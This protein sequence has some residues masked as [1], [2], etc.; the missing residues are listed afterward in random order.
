MHN[1][2][3]R[4]TTVILSPDHKSVTGKGVLPAEEMAG[5]P[6]EIRREKVKKRIF[7]LIPFLVIGVSLLMLWAF[8]AQAQEPGEE[9][10]AGLEGEGPPPGATIIQVGGAPA[11][12]D[13]PPPPPPPR[14]QR[15][16]PPTFDE[17]AAMDLEGVIRMSPPSNMGGAFSTGNYFFDDMESGTA[18]W[19]T[20]GLWHL[21]DDSDTYGNSYSATHSWWFGQNSTGNYD[22][23][24]HVTG[25][26]QT[27]SSINIPA[28]IPVCYLRFWS[29]EM[30]EDFL[31][32]YDTRRVYFS[33]DGG[34]TWLPGIYQSTASYG[35]WRR[36]H[37]DLG[38][39]L[40]PYAAAQTLDLRFEF[41][42]VD[43]SNN[44]YRGWYI[45][46]I[47]VG[48]DDIDIWMDTDGSGMGPP[49][50][51]DPYVTYGCAGCP[52]GMTPGGNLNAQDWAAGPN[53]FDITYSSP[54]WADV[55][56]WL[57]QLGVA[58]PQLGPF[59]TQIPAGTA[60]GAHQDISLTV[61][62]NAPGTR[63]NLSTVRVYHGGVHLYS[64]Q[65]IDDGSGQSVGNGNGQIDPGEIIE[66]V[67]T[68]E[69]SM[70]HTRRA[71]Q[72]VLTDSW[73]MSWLPAWQAY[74]DIGAGA[75]ASSVGKYLF[76]VPGGIPPGTLVTF[77][78][79]ITDMVLT[80]WNDSFQETVPNLTAPPVSVMA[81]AS[82]VYHRF[83]VR[84]TLQ[85]PVATNFDIGV[86][87]YTWPSVVD[88][89]QIAPPGGVLP[90]GWGYFTVTVD[91]PA[92]IAPGTET[93]A[94]VVV[95]ATAS[96][97][98]ASALIST[99]MMATDWVQ[100][101]ADDVNTPLP[102][103]DGAYLAVV[104]SMNRWTLDGGAHGPVPPPF[105]MHDPVVTAFRYDD[106]V[107]YA[108]SADRTNAY[109][110]PVREVS[111]GARKMDG[112][113][114]I[115]NTRVA[116]YSGCFP[117]PCSQ[118]QNPSIARVPTNGNIV[119]AWERQQ[120]LGFFDVYYAVYSANGTLLVG[121][122]N[123]TNNTG[124]TGI[125]DYSP[126]VEAF[127]DGRVALAWE[128]APPNLPI[129]PMSPPPFPLPPLTPHATSD[130]MYAILDEDGNMVVSTTNLTN[131]QSVWSETDWEP[132]LTQLQ[133]YDQLLVT[134][135]G[136][137]PA[138]FTFP[139]VAY[140]VLNSAGT[141][142]VGEQWLSSPLTENG[143]PNQ[144]PDA[145][146][147]PDG[148][149]VVAWSWYD[150]AATQ[151]RLLYS[152]LSSA[153]NV[154]VNP[155]VLAT[156]NLSSP[157]REQNVSL[158][159]DQSG[160][161]VLTWFDDWASPGSYG[162]LWY[163]WLAGDGTVLTSPRRYWVPHY[164]D[165]AFTN[166]WAWV[167]GYGQ[168]T[169]GMEIRDWQQLSV[170]K[171]APSQVVVGE[172]LTYTITVS[173]TGGVYT[174]AGV[175]VTDTVPANTTCCAS[176]GQGGLLVGND[177]TWSGLTISGGQSISL[178]FAVT[179]GQVASGTIITNDAY[180]VV[181]S[182]HRVTTGL[183]SEVTTTVLVPQLSIGKSA[184]S[185]VLPGSLMTYTLNVA[186][187][188]GQ[189]YATGVQVTDT[190]PA[191]TAVASIGQG[192]SLAGGEVVW[193][194]Q[195]V[196]QGSS[197]TLTF[198]VTV[199]QVSSG[200]IITND[201]YRVVSSDQGVNT[202]LGSAVTTT[203]AMP[204]LS[205]SKSAPSQVRP[206]ESL[207]YTL[208]VAETSGLLD[209]TGVQVTDTVPA[210]TA[211]AS[212]DQGGS[213]VGNDVTWSGLTVTRGQSIKL[214]FVVTV[215]SSVPLGTI[216]TNDAYRVVTSTQGINTGLGSAVNTTVSAV[217]APQLSINK[218]APSWVYSGEVLNYTIIVSETT[219]LGGAT[220]VQVTDTVPL[221]ATCCA[222][223][224]QGGSLVGNDVTWSSLV[225]S[226]GQ[227]ISLTFAVT[228]GKVLSGTII[229]N[230]AYRVVTSDQGVSTGLGNAV[231]T[232]VRMKP[233]FL[234]VI[235]SS[236]SATTTVI[237]Q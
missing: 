110:V 33:T 83:A 155:T 225:I 25:D 92:G 15:P 206:G 185:Q 160:N 236:P 57:P 47:A 108:W 10:V 183:G 180:Q 5:R 172:V 218:S 207:T 137:N 119:V 21:A 63:S 202:G 42:S 87:E 156:P 35:Q 210:N 90:L 96:S 4:R 179:V 122:T 1:T 153:L 201:A 77:N 214:T 216:I 65:I 175:Q 27:A 200:T 123:L 131:N 60:L 115:P 30:T 224:G 62:E 233:V 223:V 14:G 139:R 67:V 191:N 89:V 174:V 190:V 98:V 173:E 18:N 213:L 44:G 164:L 203:V 229:T 29:W 118:D 101:Y 20:S 157:T 152:V 109:G 159:A 199:G 52:S 75:T 11:S 184:A 51:N 54:S 204:Q 39:W 64:Y 235:R 161:A 116:D 219:G 193:S 125:S 120:I 176:I 66:L 228:V 99:T 38:P 61:T 36:H 147:L 182:T 151:L 167:S 40:A 46:D 205:V 41:D 105:Q 234:P 95:T 45:D 79:A 86:F 133:A 48:Y 230:N 58:L 208:S 43:G 59:A 146:S 141:V 28:G 226:S 132:V 154:V 3:K 69:N 209:I 19:T 91:I 7:L 144:T 102:L 73:G 85:P 84:N 231:N 129:Y 104:Q 24:A 9:P 26:L 195:T 127:R 186:E 113:V 196:S 142:S 82:P 187:T 220:G 149:I 74:G 16:L 188:T 145:V 162:D 34:L 117:G 53:P 71:V 215:G 68:L 106:T 94:T 136:W 124:A 189:A 194:G 165:P 2:A 171:S 49:W 72:A 177:V 107:A 237:L 121:P 13:Q 81:G 50:W 221:S 217:S 97:D 128:H 222:S 168:G 22:T 135:Q 70:D 232:T 31:G 211:L 56:A 78:L 100:V 150:A 181:T 192:G 130:I 143:L 111:F 23:G 6:K 227:S 138:V 37:V 169:G 103:V 166:R 158:V 140:A 178:T 148:H 80:V 170:G 163:A 93:T 12:Q 126:A 134:W 88:P 212:I 114:V 112:T 8:A 55:G 17:M 76:Q 197:L 32:T 198:V